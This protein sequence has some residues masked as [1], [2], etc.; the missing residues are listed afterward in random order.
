M[1]ITIA[2]VNYHLRLGRPRYLDLV[3]FCFLYLYL[4]FMSYNHIRHDGALNQRLIIHFRANLSVHCT[5][6]RK[7]IR[8]FGPPLSPGWF[9]SSLVVPG[10]LV[11][12]CSHS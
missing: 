1:D 3:D 9:K 10:C 5:H 12:S 2:L 6:S 11:P 8:S 7:L 4:G